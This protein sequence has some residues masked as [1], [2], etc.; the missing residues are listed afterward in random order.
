MPAPVSVQSIAAGAGRRA[1]AGAHADAAA[2]SA[3]SM[4]CANIRRVGQLCGLELVERPF[5]ERCARLPDGVS[6]AVNP[7][8]ASCRRP[9]SHAAGNVRYRHPR[10][11]PASEPADLSLAHPANWR[12]LPPATPHAVARWARCEPA[13]RSI[14]AKGASGDLERQREARR[15]ASDPVPRAVAGDADA[16]LGVPQMRLADGYLRLRLR[17]QRACACEGWRGCR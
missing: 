12:A 15:E 5:V 6:S 14:T 10:S 3:S 8:A 16:G 11:A 13:D 9:L 4:S 17:Q 7:H 2:R 1:L